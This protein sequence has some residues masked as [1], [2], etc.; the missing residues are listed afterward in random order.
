MSLRRVIVCLGEGLVD[1]ICER[2]V[3]SLVEADSFVPRFGGAL[4]N[5]A[6]AASRA[7]AEAGLAGAAGDDEWGSWLRERL[8]REGVDLRFFELIEGEQT[9]VAFATTDAAGES[10]FQIYGEAIA[11]AVA[12]VAPRLEAAID[13]ADALVYSSTTLA[14]PDEREVTLRAREL[15]LER[16]ARVCFD[17]NIRPNR[18]GGDP[19]PAAEASR[20]LIE[21][22]FVVRTNRAEAIAIAGVDDPRRA[23]D[24]LAAMGA[25]LAVVTLGAEGAVMRG[26][27]EAEAPAPEVDVVSSLG[28]GDALMGT[29][30]AELAKR[31]WD[32][33][34]A[35]ETLEP[36]LAAA[37]GACTRWAALD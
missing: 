18:W 12:S 35:A 1:L 23:A 8:A 7:G 15:A 21:G 32:T 29:L 30:V 3:G 22:S 16:G 11:I 37:A 33:A 9:P 27:C 19:R 5:V 10:S 24:R 34:R 28:A 31:E 36:A 26:A 6:V 2:P 17:P 14:T 20:A 25:E 4:A 13:A